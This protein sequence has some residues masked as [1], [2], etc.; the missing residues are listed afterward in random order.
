MSKK[1][2]LLL[3]LA[4]LAAAGAG[5]ADWAV[6][7]HRGRDYVSFANVGQFYQMPQHHRDLRSVSL[8]SDRR[9][10][11]AS[12]DKSEVFINGVRFFTHFPIISS[13][14]REL[15]SSID[16]TK[17]LDPILR[18][19]QIEASRR[20]DTVILDPGHGGMD[21]G[22]HNRWGTEK[23]FALDVALKAR[24]YLMQAGF[25]V[26]MTR[27]KDEAK[28]LDERLAFA[29]R[30]P[31]AVLI[32][33]HFNTGGGSGVES[34]ALAPAGVPSSSSGEDNASTSDMK[35]FEGNRRDSLNVALTAAVH[36]SILSRLP[37]IDRGVRHA[38]FRI[39]REAPVPA[40]LI[41]GGFLSNPG[42]ASRIATAQY[43]QQLAFA[44]AQAVRSFDAAVNYR[45]SGANFAVAMSTLPPHSESIAEP[46]LTPEPGRLREEQTPS[47]TIQGG[48]RS[49]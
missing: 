35:L 36:A 10:L 44:I 3:L 8:R 16:V 7:R 13:D 24:A 4:S 5:A 6:H 33:I 40:V 21:Q 42:D 11:R 46:L 23:E 26:E 28:S 38:R 17:I 15:I 29:A 30:F 2:L 47:V 20:I 43:R 41:E 45:T 39:L 31:N 9:R 14:G 34:Y 37:M 32:S 18:P 1:I 19:H 27:V 48:P 12:I 22:T 25:R 49:R